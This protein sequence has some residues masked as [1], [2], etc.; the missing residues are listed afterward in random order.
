MIY[1][2][3]ASLRMATSYGMSPRQRMLATRWPL[4]KLLAQL[5]GTGAGATATAGCAGLWHPSLD[6]EE[7]RHQAGCLGLKLVADCWVVSQGRSMY[8]VY[9]YC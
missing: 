7:W 3:I 1:Q 2:F 6:W 8:T 5:Q 4:L 9:T